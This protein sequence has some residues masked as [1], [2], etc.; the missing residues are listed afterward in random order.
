M[1]PTANSSS[2][3]R[4]R[5]IGRRNPWNRSFFSPR[6]NVDEF[7]PI[8][9][10][11]RPAPMSAILTSSTCSDHRVPRLR[12]PI[13]L[14]HGLF[15][16]DSLRLGPWLLAQYFQGIPETLRRAGN[17]VLVAWL[18]PTGGIVE[19]ARQLKELLDRESPCEPVHLI[20][21]SMGGLDSRYLISRLGMAPRVL[22]LTTLGTPHRGSAFADWGIRRLQRVLQPLFDFVNV[23]YQAFFDLTTARCAEFNRQTPDAPGVRYFSVAGDFLLRWLTPEWQIPARILYRSEGPNDG[24]VSVASA[25][26]GEDLTTWDG[27]HLNLIN[28]KHSWVPARRQNDRTSHYAD[29]VRRLADEGY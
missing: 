15:G 16:F 6:I 3:N 24:V 11:A 20:A 10:A 25:T 7:D 27:D 4:G 28:W 17:R 12:A 21:H 22:T 1:V 2:V 18:S 23:P 26:W 13:V 9:Q 29:L 19:R 14:V 5:S 8:L